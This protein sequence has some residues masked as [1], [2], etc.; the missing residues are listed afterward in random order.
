MLCRQVF[1]IALA[2]SLPLLAAGQSPSRERSRATITGAVTD[3]ALNPIDAAEISIA[4]SNARTRSDA[5]GKFELG[6]LPA[7]NY[8]LAVR[9]LG[10][11]T[12]ATGVTVAAGDTLRLAF[13]LTPTAEALPSVTVSAPSGSMRLR[14]FEERRK[15]GNGQFFDQ[16][17]IESRNVAGVTDLLR[18]AKAVR[19]ATDGT[20]LFAES[21]REWTPCPMQVYLDGIPL[22]G[23]GVSTSAKFDLKL[24]PSPKQIMAI[25][26]YAGAASLPPGLPTGPPS[27]RAGC[28]AILVWTRDGSSPQD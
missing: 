25:E 21:A 17:Y 11:E 12:I 15:R 27:G 26:V 24:L 8:V 7:G 22:A 4:F 13:T 23:V 20:H 2:V 16:Q 3:T 9:R 28:G 5:H 14:E 19:M 18:E 10:Y 1:P 6:S